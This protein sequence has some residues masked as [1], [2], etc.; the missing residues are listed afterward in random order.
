[1]TV[2][3]LALTP[4][5]ARL[6]DLLQLRDRSDLAALPAVISLGLYIFLVF[7]FLSRRCERQADIFGCRTVSC[8]NPSCP[9]HADDAPPVRKEGAL[10]PVGVQTFIHA[11]EKVAVL[12]GISREKPGFLQSWQHSTI[13]RRV[14]FLRQLM[15][16]PKVEP[17][18]QKRIFLVK[19]ALFA[20]LG[21]ILVVQLV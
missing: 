15:C 21:L 2:L 4:Y 5:Q 1:M 13:A 19:C 10:C 9:G 3:G 20:V 7:G 8:A 6:D 16:D 14:E 11:L 18:F 17:R 12:N